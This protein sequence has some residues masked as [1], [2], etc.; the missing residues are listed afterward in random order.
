MTRKKKTFRTA[1]QWRALI[2]AHTASGQTQQDFCQ[3]SS[4]S[5]TSFQKW[6][7]RLRK[8]SEAKFIE[9]TPRAD[10]HRFSGAKLELEIAGGITLRMWS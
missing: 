4:L 2:A 5:L 1:D 3:E 8:E 9:V 10:G 7:R 6:R